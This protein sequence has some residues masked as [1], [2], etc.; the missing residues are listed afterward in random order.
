MNEDMSKYKSLS[1]KWSHI[2]CDR[3]GFRYG[4]LSGPSFIILMFPKW[5]INSKNFLSEID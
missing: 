2:A 1:D 5:N 3:T 4:T